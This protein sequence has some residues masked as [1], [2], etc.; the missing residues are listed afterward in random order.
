M[1]LKEIR[2]GFK[3]SQLDAANIANIPL[4]TYV[5]YEFDEEYGDELKR[6]MIIQMLHDKCEINEEKGLLNLAE[7]S[8]VVT[9]IFDRDYKDEIDFCYLFGS[10]AKGCAKESSDIDLFISTKLTGFKFAGISEKLRESFHK[11]I[12]LIRIDSV[13]DN[14]DLL[15]EIMKDGIKIYVSSRE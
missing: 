6:K 8:H 5:R 13:K 12:D 3:L 1:S 7:I 9:R 2:K 11:K 14:F 15:N 10:Y 4:R